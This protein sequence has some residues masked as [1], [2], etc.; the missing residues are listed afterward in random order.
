MSSSMGRKKRWAEGYLERVEDNVGSLNKAQADELF[1]LRTEDIPAR[2]R[3]LKEQGLSGRQA[4]RVR[5]R[6]CE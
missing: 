6:G 4:L 3:A 1:R 5:L 2:K